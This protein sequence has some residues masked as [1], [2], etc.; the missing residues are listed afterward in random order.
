MN[1]KQKYY[2]INESSFVSILIDTSPANDVN[3]SVLIITMNNWCRF[4]I[5]NQSDKEILF[6]VNSHRQYNFQW[7][8]Q[9]GHPI[10]H[11][12]KDDKKC[13]TLVNRSDWRD[14]NE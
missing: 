13:W 10:F 3:D 12:I 4:G 8:L 6:L 14:G 9:M 5:S 1:L 2:I 7:Q 11:Y